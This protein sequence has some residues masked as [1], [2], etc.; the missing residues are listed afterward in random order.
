MSSCKQSGQA[1]FPFPCLKL[2]KLQISSNVKESAKRCIACLIIHIFVPQHFKRPWWP[3]PGKLWRTLTGHWKVFFPLPNLSI[4]ATR[5]YISCMRCKLTLT[6]QQLLQSHSTSFWANI[7]G[8][9]CPEAFGNC[10]LTFTTTRPRTLPANIFLGKCQKRSAHTR[11]IT[12]AACR[13]A[14]LHDTSWYWMI[15]LIC[16]CCHI[17][18]SLSLSR[19][20][21]WCY[22]CDL[23]TTTLGQ[24]CALIA[25]EGTYWTIEIKSKSEREREKNNQKHNIQEQKRRETNNKQN[26]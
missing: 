2:Y 12:Q 24:E 6:P 25:C 16:W 18:H 21:L 15:L 23:H 7:F 3:C 14:K 13:I 26:R 10:Q 22:S 4:R 20:H 9:P 1:E 19:F 17:S 11:K 5:N 8:A